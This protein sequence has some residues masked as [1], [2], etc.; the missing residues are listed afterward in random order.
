MSGGIKIA[1][2][3]PLRASAAIGSDAQPVASALR[4]GCPAGT[5]IFRRS[6]VLRFILALVGSV[7][8]STAIAADRPNVLFLMSDDLRPELG[9]YGVEGIQ[10]PNIDGLAAKGVRFERAYVQYP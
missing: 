10:T 9:C 4:F 7:A 2:S 6:A 8:V 1:E 3:S 5:T